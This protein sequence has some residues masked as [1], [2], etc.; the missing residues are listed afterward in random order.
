L[1]SQSHAWRSGQM[2]AACTRPTIR[3]RPLAHHGRSL[4][5]RPAGRKGRSRRPCHICAGTWLSPSTSAPGVG[6]V[7]E[8][9][10]LSTVTPHVLAVAPPPR[11][12]VRQE[13]IRSECLRR[14][15]RPTRCSK[16]ESPVGPPRH[17]PAPR[18]RTDER[19]ARGPRPALRGS[20]KRARRPSMREALTCRP[21]LRSCS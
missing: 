17:S 11:G 4:P 13:G 14:S 20:N 8:G 2:S 15:I 3:P 1:S 16:S 7:A 6:A 9:L 18:Q 10:Q 21:L 19:R 12:T 5:C